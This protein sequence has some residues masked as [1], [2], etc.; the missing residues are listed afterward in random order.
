[1]NT[2]INTE[3][4][5]HTSKKQK[6]LL[7]H[8][9]I[10]FFGTNILFLCYNQYYMSVNET[11]PNELKNVSGFQSIYENNISVVRMPNLPANCRLQLIAVAINYH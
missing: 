8:F 9:D 6:K 10:D 11:C 3:R 1:M 2:I 4:N 7:H 5:R